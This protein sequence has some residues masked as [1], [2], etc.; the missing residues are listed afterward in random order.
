MAEQCF[1]RWALIVDPKN[2]MA[3]MNYALV[4]Q[5]ITGDYHKAEYYYRR[6]LTIAPYEPRLLHNFE[7]FLKHR[8]P[9]GAYG[10]S[11]P[12]VFVVKR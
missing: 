2:P 9:G 11:G 4:Q 7:D 8:L 10:T 1:F 6:A 5:G 12:S 3:M